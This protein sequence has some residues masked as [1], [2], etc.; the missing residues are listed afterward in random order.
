MCCDEGSEKAGSGDKEKITDA[1]V[2]QTLMSG[3]RSNDVRTSFIGYNTMTEKLFAFV[4][5]R[6]RAGFASTAVMP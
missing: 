2:G 6:S 5:L 4:R 3:I 1:M